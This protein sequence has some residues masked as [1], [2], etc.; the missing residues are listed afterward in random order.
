MRA[1]I[2]TLQKEIG[3]T[4]IY[5]THDQV[6]A[7]TIGDRVALMRRGE[8]LQFAEPQDLYDRP[9][10]LFVAAF[11]G[12]PPMNL[13]EAEV[14]RTDGGCWLAVGDRQIALGPRE[15]AAS[16]RLETYI[17]RTVVA[18]IRP[19][20]LE[21]AAFVADA[22]VERR[23]QGVA[24]LREALG[25]DALVHFTVDGSRALASHVR[26]LA[27]DIEDPAQLQEPDRDE[28]QIT[29][30][31]RFQPHSGARVGEPVEV[32]IQ[33]RALMLFDPETGHRI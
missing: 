6:E 16:A 12:S 30:I 8:L 19:E 21:D 29:F 27:H 25:S 20:S 11:V 5:V 1:E 23:L 31:G 15:V 26:E 7:M 13:I 9:A 3:V 33:P 22:P 17:G 18:G 24:T 14:S 4:T 2:S 32:A 10:N 28:R